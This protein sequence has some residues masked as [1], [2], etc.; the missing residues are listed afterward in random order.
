[1]LEWAGRRGDRVSSALLPTSAREAPMGAFKDITGQRFGRLT[2]LGRIG[3]ANGAALWDC[4]CRCGGRVLVRGWDLCK[5]SPNRSCGCWHRERVSA[6]MMIHGGCGTRVYQAW[7]N[8]RS[9]CGN[10]KDPKYP[11]WGGRGI[12]VCERWRDFEVF[13]N[14]MG[15]M[16]FAGATLERVDNDGDYSPDNCRWA[17]RLEQANNRG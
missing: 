7:R 17:T 4:R 12:S 15:P 16:P 6:R 1:M 3:T 2:A 9:R 10:R 14:D 8:M 5:R 13:R 11:R